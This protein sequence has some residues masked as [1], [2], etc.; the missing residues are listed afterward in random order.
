M[1]I[2]GKLI[3]NISSFKKGILDHIS[4]QLNKQLRKFNNAED[5]IKDIVIASIKAQDEYL[6]L[7]SGT[8]RNQFG[9]ENPGLADAVLQSLE[10]IDIKINRARVNGSEIESQIIINMIKSDYSDMLSSSAASYTSEKGSTIPWLEWLLLR[11][12]D[13][14]VVGFKY[15]P[16]NSPYSRTGRGIMISGDS[17]IY[18]VPPGYAGTMDNNWITR[19]VDAALP[20]IQ[21]Y[22][23]SLVEKI[24]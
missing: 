10:N 1:N 22:M 19:G 8:L 2:F 3:T 6:S 13:S 4:K 11:G 24:L 15:L 5:R 23:N 9:L 20:E 18:R 12:Q 21:S 7:K 16:K 17:A 14:V